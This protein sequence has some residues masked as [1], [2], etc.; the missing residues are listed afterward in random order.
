MVGDGSALENP[1]QCQTY[2]LH[3]HFIGNNMGTGLLYLTTTIK[4]SPDFFLTVVNPARWWIRKGFWVDVSPHRP[5]IA[6]SAPYAILT[7]TLF[8]PGLHGVGCRGVVGCRGGCRRAF[9]S[10]PVPHPFPPATKEVWS[11]IASS[12]WDLC[13]VWRR[14]IMGRRW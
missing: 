12:V 5:H 7:P 1:L 3:T 9:S 6:H 4:L 13:L 10:S 8:R 2:S 14:L 11:D